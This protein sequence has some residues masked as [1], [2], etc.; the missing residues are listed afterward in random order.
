M[1]RISI[2]ALALALTPAC[3]DG[4]EADAGAFDELR[5]GGGQLDEDADHPYVARLWTE[6]IANS[7]SCSGVLITPGLILTANHCLRH[8]SCASAT[9]V[10][11]LSQEDW[12]IDLGDG[13]Y[14]N[15]LSVE[16]SHTFVTKH[17]GVLFESPAI[18]RIGGYVDMCTKDDPSKDLAILRLDKRVPISEVTPVH[19]PLKPEYPSCHSFFGDDFEGTIVGFGKC[20][21][22]NGGACPGETDES[23]RPRTTWTSGGWSRVWERPLFPYEIFA[24]FVWVPLTTD[25]PGG[26]Y[27]K[28]VSFPPV[29]EPQQS[30][31]PDPWRGSLPGDSGGPLV[32]AFNNPALF[33]GVQSNIV[34]NHD[35]LM[36]CGVSSREYPATPDDINPWFPLQRGDDYAAVDGSGEVDTDNDNWLFD[37]VIAADNNFIGECFAGDPSQESVLALRDQDR[38]DDLIPDLC[39]PCPDFYDHDY[40]QGLAVTPDLD[41]DGVPDRCDSC[42]TIANPDMIWGPPGAFR[43]GQLDADNDGY[44]DACDTCPSSDLVPLGSND[45]E[46]LPLAIY[47]D[48]TCCTTDADCA[49]DPACPGFVDGQ[50]LPNT[51]ICIPG[52][53]RG[54]IIDYLDDNAISFELCTAHCATPVDTDCDKHGDL[55]DDCPTNSD[56]AQTDADHDGIGDICDNCPGGKTPHAEDLNPECDWF[57]P[58]GREVCESWHP[59]SVCL[60]P[61]PDHGPDAAVS[62]CTLHPDAD[63]DFRGDACDSCELQ[64]NPKQDNCNV[65]TEIH[66]GLAYPYIGD[67]CD[68]N[69]CTSITATQ[70]IVPVSIEDE[71]GWVAEVQ[72]SPRLLPP[73]QP[74]DPHYGPAFGFDC[75]TEGVHCDDPRATTGLRFCPCDE[76]DP[77][78]G[79]PDPLACIADG[80]WIDSFYYNFGSN[81]WTPSIWDDVA[82][83]NGL[84]FS[85]A[86]IDD[87]PM[88]NPVPGDPLGAGSLLPDGSAPPSKSYWYVSKDLA[89]NGGGEQAIGILWSHV[90]WVTDLE[91]TPQ[92]AK[93]EYEPYSNYYRG[94]IWG[95][96]PSGWDEDDVPSTWKPYIYK[97]CPLELIAFATE[98]EPTLVIDAAVRPEDD[99]HV[100]YRTAGNGLVLTHQIADEAREALKQTNVVWVAGAEMLDDPSGLP[101]LVA[102]SQ[103]GLLVSSVLGTI[104]GRMIELSDADSP[105]PQIIG[106]E[107]FAAA[108]SATQSSLY[109]IGGVDARTQLELGDVL[110]YDIGARS[111]TQLLLSGERPGSVL[112]A[113]YR[114]D[115]NALYAV[116]V[117][118]GSA[119]LLHIDLSTRHSTILGQWTRDARWDHTWL[120]NTTDGRLVLVA[121]AD[122]SGYAGMAFDPAVDLRRSSDESFVTF[123]GNQ[124]LVGA[125]TLT[126]R[127]LTLR[128]H[129]SDLGVANE[130]RPFVE[131][132][133]AR[134]SHGNSFAVVL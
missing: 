35:G 6:G 17:R 57:L 74:A 10:E 42:A 125:P 76:L 80:C 60:P 1:R 34:G 36:L 13:V 115:D 24:Q 15:D 100:A 119:R 16:R 97:G 116:D 110:R 113:T 73:W 14:S 99:L 47:S 94:G 64:P 86:E 62:R 98:D 103:D 114:M 43:F 18:E 124:R 3:D 129:H 118:N 102:L 89:A 11:D 19:V 67:A 25:L 126:E 66:D 68:R 27:T 128:V 109:V 123:A 37:H 69:P 38:D 83:V 72:Y 45:P 12:D 39:D 65:V 84:Y 121:A 78:T 70:K 133:G 7:T 77:T 9:A 48:F 33:P 108:L 71:V 26:T 127:G 8:D 75:I 51:N 90:S 44:G 81:W 131:L 88:I 79:T 30:A 55:C 49:P 105:T 106:R 20:S 132:L 85:E 82:I 96:P 58:G 41:S 63:G 111:W 130:F 46:A 120:G 54:L 107:A 112:A 5:I 56:P 52:D 23:G 28:Y 104:G 53:S 122:G 101:A 31:D 2:P 29:D 87:Q 59:D 22:L 40:D 134:G 95:P 4:H 92:D 117:K 61:H 32:G 93:D 21:E 91:P 50:T